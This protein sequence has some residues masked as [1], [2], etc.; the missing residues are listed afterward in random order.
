MRRWLPLL[1]VLLLAAVALF[2]WRLY[3]PRRQPP[4]DDLAGLLDDLPHVA[5]VEGDVKGEPD[6]VVHLRD[7]HLVPRD[8]FVKD[9]K[10][11]AKRN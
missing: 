3:S 10:A 2:A 6:R 1:T 9:V 11:G 5:S 7:W 4:P 8:A